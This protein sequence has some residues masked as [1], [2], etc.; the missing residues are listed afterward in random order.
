MTAVDWLYELWYKTR[1]D[2]IPEDFEQAKEIEK[3]QIID[4]Y[5][6]NENYMCDGTEAE[7]YYDGKFKNK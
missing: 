5:N 1:G 2:L 3:Q 6:E 4:A 7:Q